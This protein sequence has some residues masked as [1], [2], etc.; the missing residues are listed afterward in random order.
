MNTSKDVAKQEYLYTAGQMQVST[1]TLESSME[2]P[3][4]TRDKTAI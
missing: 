1:T 3:Q 4:T 2:I